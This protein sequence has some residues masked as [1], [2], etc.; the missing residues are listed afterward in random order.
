MTPDLRQWFNQ[1]LQF[2]PKGLYKDIQLRLWIELKTVNPK[3]PPVPLRVPANCESASLNWWLKGETATVQVPILPNGKYGVKIL[4]AGNL[5]PFPLMISYRQHWIIWALQDTRF[6]QIHGNWIFPSLRDTLS[7]RPPIVIVLPPFGM[8][9]VTPLYL[10]ELSPEPVSGS[11]RIPVEKAFLNSWQLST[12]P[13]CLTPTG[14][15]QRRG[16]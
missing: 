8:H 7:L 12:L 14:S 11:F 1:D 4:Y 13:S 6:T 16:S 5:L 9:W 2:P 3:H 10:L 15:Y